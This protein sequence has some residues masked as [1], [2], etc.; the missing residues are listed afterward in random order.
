MLIFKLKYYICQMKT[1]KDI[2]SEMIQN[3]ELALNPSLTS[4][5]YN[6]LANRNNYLK[7]VLLYLETNPNESFIR[8]EVERLKKLI[9]SKESQYIKWSK[10]VCPKEIDVKKR[11]E[12]CRTKD[13]WKKNIRNKT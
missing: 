7:S 2:K 3:V 6:T 9:S 12:T 5:G 10:D 8:S 11:K 13:K 4:R 1:I